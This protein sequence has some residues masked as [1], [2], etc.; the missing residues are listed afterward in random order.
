MG[1]NGKDDT[2]TPGGS[3]IFRYDDP[4]KDFSLPDRDCVYLDDIEAHIERHIGPVETVLH[5]FV[6]DK[7]HLDVLLVEPSPSC[8]AWTYVTSGM[9]DLPM[10]LPPDLPDPELWARAE[11]FI[12]LPSDWL[13]QEGHAVFDAADDENDTEHLWYPIRWLKSLARFPHNFDTWFGPGH[14][15]PNGDPAEPI[16]PGTQMTGFLMNAS[17]SYDV[18]FDRIEATDGNVINLY[19]VYPLYTE[20]MD[21]KLNKGSDALMDRLAA[22]DVNEIYRPN[23][24]SVAV[25][26]KFLGLF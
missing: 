19:A 8:D 23:R 5:E 11:L 12:Q 17:I 16:G 3:E 21:F 9:S 24:A 2:R 20:E 14:T 15:M 22:A 10:T 4:P 18:A 25:R 1:E 26:K 13:P 6:S 7:V